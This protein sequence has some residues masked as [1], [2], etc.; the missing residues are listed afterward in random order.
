MGKKREGKVENRRPLSLSL[1]L[2]RKSAA[3]V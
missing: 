3:T 1:S 2:S